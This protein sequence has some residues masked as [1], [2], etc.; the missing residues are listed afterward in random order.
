M[1]SWGPCHLRLTTACPCSWARLPSCEGRSAA[2]ARQAAW[3]RTPRMA[4]HLLRGPG[5]FT[6]L[7]VPVSS[8]KSGEETST[9]PWGLL[10]HWLSRPVPELCLQRRPAP[11][12]RPLA[13][14]GRRRSGPTRLPTV[15]CA[16]TPPPRCR[17]S[18]RGGAN[19]RAGAGDGGEGRRA[20]ESGGGRGA[21]RQSLHAHEGQPTESA[22]WAAGARVPHR[23]GAQMCLHGAVAAETGH[24]EAS[25]PAQLHGT[26]SPL[27]RRPEDSATRPGTSHSARS[28]RKGTQGCPW[29]SAGQWRLRFGAMLGVPFPWTS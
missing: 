13:P 8:I 17:K 28:H 3:I 6:D 25:A 26:P 9:S 20:A 7:S 21:E 14:A 2:W 1:W 11:R 12:H 4:G 10:W 16:K 19:S 18:L 5:K 27:G 15:G 24:S 23:R 22:S 29:G